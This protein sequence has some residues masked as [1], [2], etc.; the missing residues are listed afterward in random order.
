MNDVAQLLADCPDAIQVMWNG[1]TTAG[2]YKVSAS[3]EDGGG[4]LGH[5]MLTEV[6]VIA[7][8]EL[9]GL[10]KDDA[11]A[12]IRNGETL[13]RKVILALPKEDDPALLHVQVRK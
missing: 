4:R 2:L 6:L 12:F 1:I 9:P 10:K 11:I 8:G 7:E 5:A 3:I 13:N